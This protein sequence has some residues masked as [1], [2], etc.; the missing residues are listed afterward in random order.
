MAN[1]ASRS[2]ACAAAF[3]RAIDVEWSRNPMDPANFLQAPWTVRRAVAERQ[4]DVV[5]VHTPL[6]AFI[7]R[8]ALRGGRLAKNPA[9]A[10]KIIYT[11]HGFYFH[12]AGF[13]V[14]NFIYRNL[15][16]VAGRWTDYLVVMN[17]MDEAAARQYRLVPEGSLVYMPGIGVDLSY[18]DNASVPASEVERV[19]A[20][21]GLRP[22]DVVFLMLAE[23]TPKKRHADAL[24]ALATLD[25]PSVHLALGGDGPGMQATQELA[26]TLGVSDR[27]HFLGFRTDVPA[28]M[29]ASAAL[30]LPSEQEGLPRC[31]MEAM[32]M[33]KAV[34]ATDIR[35]THDL[36][37]GGAGILLP[38]G[39]YLR[40]ADKMRWV[41][42]H[43]VE[44]ASIAQVGRQK[45][46]S[47]EIGHILHLHELL[48]ERALVQQAE[49]HANHFAGTHDLTLERR[50]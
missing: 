4:Y 43:P 44:A 1:G 30:L 34:I 10:P 9:A 6:A 5:H 28:L 49:A 25:N 37:E 18:Y 12:P 29:S 23:F 41:M 16:T 24:R 21:L 17:R 11:A 31:V 8:M 26:R 39:E 35:G 46:A 40:L 45:I 14:S 3:D 22:E 32:C 20:E 13:P 15:E 38:V 19:R 33:E 42:D 36:L 2:D 48:Y 7:V 47:Y 50:R 27:V